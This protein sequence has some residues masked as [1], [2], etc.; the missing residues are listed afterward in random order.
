MST[1]QT[2]A[3][4][5]AAF[6]VLIIWF[7]KKTSDYFRNMDN[8]IGNVEL[9]KTSA[10]HK[11]ITARKNVATGRSGVSIAFRKGEKLYGQVESIDKM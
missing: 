8:A 4:S 2:L 5:F 3:L 1:F 9:N 10:I 6:N 11:D 7:F